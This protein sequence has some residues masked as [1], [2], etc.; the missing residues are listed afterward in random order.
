LIVL[1]VGGGTS[2]DLPKDYKGWDQH[3]LDID[4]SVAP[5][6]LCD[7]KDMR[8]LKAGQYDSIFCSHNLEHFHK[9]EV[10]TV[11]AGFTHVLKP[12]GYAHIVV[13]DLQ[14]LFDAITKGNHDIDDIWYRASRPI[15][16]HD[17]LYG[18]GAMLS[19]GNPY[20]AH[21]CG[22]TEKS[23]TKTLKRHFKHVFTAT[24]DFGN[25]YA[26]AFKSKPTKEQL[27]CL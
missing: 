5:D 6:V 1:N 11:L 26:Y 24:D 20:Y 23:L 16:F 4:A 10:P 9:H 21:K 27:K 3:I 22:F 13:P 19:Q 15:S 12:N 25:L 2:R 18:W 14:Q 7:A 17:V 8:K